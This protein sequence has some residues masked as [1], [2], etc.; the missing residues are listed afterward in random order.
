[1][2]WFLLSFISLSAYAGIFGHDDRVESRSSVVS[3][4]LRELSFSVPAIVELK[5]LTPEGEHFLPKGIPLLSIGFCPE[6]RF[7][8]QQYVARCSSSLIGD[9]L[10]LTAGHCVD[11]DIKK[12]CS[13]YAVVFDY[14]SGER[15][16]RNE[17]VYHCKEVLYRKFIGAFD[18]DLAVIRLTRKVNG[19]EKIRL[20]GKLPAIGEKLS[21]I[22]CP[23]GISQK[24]ADDGE[25]TQFGPSKY[26]FRHDVD[27]FSSNS[28][29]PVFNSLGEQV[30][31]LVRGTGENQDAVE[32][33][34]CFDWGIEKENGFSE[35]NT[36]LHL[37]HY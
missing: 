17:N 36:L 11:D 7:S 10:V 1:M 4:M 23:L 21:M 22:G 26:T 34:S 19:R 16:I 24:V 14:V 30:G 33:R 3:A 27:T 31:V 9:D 6:A 15:L 18:E 12:W 35:A 5:T 25:V 20:A 32:G 37:P 2:K 29:G 28:G 13:E 8:D